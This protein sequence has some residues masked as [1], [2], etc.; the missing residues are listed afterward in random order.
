MKD[1]TGEFLKL[2]VLFSALEI[3][4]RVLANFGVDVLEALGA[5]CT[6]VAR[7]QAPWAQLLADALVAQL[8]VAGHACVLMCQGVTYAV[9]MTSRRA[10]AL[11]ALLIAA[12]FVEV[13][14][15][16]HKR[17]DTRKLWT[18]AAADI[19][20]R[21]HLA[22]VLLFV[23]A[24]DVASSRSAASSLWGLPL[25]SAALVSE[26]ARVLG[27]EVAVDVAK[28]AVLGKFSDI[29][30]G[31]YR[32]Y[33][34][35]LAGD[36]LARASSD[37]HRL[38]GFCPLGPAALAVRTAWALL[39]AMVSAG[40]WSWPGATGVAAAAWVAMAAGQ[41]ALGYGL[42]A[43]AAVYL[44]G[45][46]WGLMMGGGG[47]GGGAGGGGAGPPAAPPPAPAAIAPA[48]SSLSRARAKA[49]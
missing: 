21:Y 48:S 1:I 2:T 38:V 25:P 33:M 36:A 5:T 35:D 26:A 6:L 4:D 9:A 49:E 41:A 22:V 28:H 30:P 42:K 44:R 29:R 8:L 43:A 24:E 20:E 23:A 37:A 32:E 13:K 47:G 46:G 15:V 14:G 40:G 11:L 34:R 45:G 17:Y 27:W 31:V 39:G 7:G 19:V 12:N 18:L 3:L 10:N 16:V